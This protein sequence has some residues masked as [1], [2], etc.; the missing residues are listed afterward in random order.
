MKKKKDEVHSDQVKLDHGDG[1]FNLFTD[2]D[3]K[4]SYV[5]SKFLQVFALG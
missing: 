2:N 5:M 4:V 3:M 1:L